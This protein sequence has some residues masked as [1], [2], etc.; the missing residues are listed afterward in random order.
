MTVASPNNRSID[1]KATKTNSQQ[2]D[3]FTIE[4]L[5][6]LNLRNETQSVFEEINESIWAFHNL[7]LAEF[8]I[9]TLNLGEIP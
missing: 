1:S 2:G 7:L 9:T 8:K 4:F 6:I 3:D 5:V